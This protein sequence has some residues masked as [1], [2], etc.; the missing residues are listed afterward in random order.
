M[1]VLAPWDC[2]ICL[3]RVP[4]KVA[5][6]YCGGRRA[7]P[8]GSDAG[9]GE[10][11]KMLGVG[12]AVLLLAVGAAAYLLRTPAPPASAA[13]VATATP[14][15]AASAGASAPLPSVSTLPAAW[16]ALAIELAPL[17][18]NQLLSRRSGQPWRPHPHRRRRIRSTR[19]ARR[20]LSAFEA[21]LTS[22]AARASDFREKLRRYDE[23]C[24]SANTHIVG[25]DSARSEIASLAREI[26]SGV[27]AAEEQARRSWVDPG[28]KRESR[29]RHDLDDNAIRDLLKSAAEAAK[30]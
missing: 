10:R 14:R 19:S 1:A 11:A 18:P 26:A 16:K 20:A 24:A 23:Q 27:E 29:E 25:C 22:L 28:Q 6:C 13:S 9:S 12:L 15:P 4:A 3:R 8:V 7:D 21:T 30:R 5:E 17:R 2:P